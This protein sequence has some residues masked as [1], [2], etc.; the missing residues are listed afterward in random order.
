MKKWMFIMLLVSLALF[1]SVI[2]FHL[3]VKP[4]MVAKYIANMGEPEHPVTATVIR[5][6]PWVPTIEAIGFVEPHQ[7]ITLSTEQAGTIASITFESGKPVKTGQLLLTLDSSVE[8]ANLQATQAKLP[9][10]QARF[11]R[12]QNLYQT[13]AISKE[14]LDEAQAS[15]HTLLADIESLKAVIARREVRAPFNGVIGLRN[16]FLGQYLQP[17]TDIARLE[18]TRMMRLRFTVPQTDIAKIA[19]GQAVKIN[20]DAY[21]EQPFNGRITAI[22]PAVNFQSGLI[23]VQADIPNNDGQLRSGMFARASIILPAQENQLVLP[24]SAIT[25]TLYGQN[26]YLIKK[27]QEK[28]KNQDDDKEQKIV[29]VLRVEPVVIKTGER[30]GNDV[31][32]LSGIKAGD[33]VVLSGQVRLSN[34]SKVRI[35]Q[36]SAL[37]VPAQSP[38]L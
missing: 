33:Q 24:Q 32:V 31:H 19:I 16:V 13:R 30:R 8:R 14:Q 21:P 36:D 27:H 2:G 22:E 6:K 29:E 17:G 34:N 12:L 11:N 26:V 20:V 3:I 1:G 15:Y 4:M 18:D 10:A 28:V 9:A 25:F 5:A 35:V 23:Q 37:D 7:G 38:M